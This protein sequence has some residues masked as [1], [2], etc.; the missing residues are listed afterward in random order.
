MKKNIKF[1][2]ALN[3]LEEIIEKLETG[4]DD[5]DSVVSLYEEGMELANYCSSKLE[6]IENKIEILSAKNTK[7]NPGNGV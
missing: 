4:V 5:L 3:R 6:K 2:T 1:E 7:A